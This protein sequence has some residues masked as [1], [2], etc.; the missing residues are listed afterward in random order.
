MPRFYSIIENEHIRIGCTGETVWVLD[1]NDTVLA[2]FKDLSY[3]YRAAISPRGDLLAVKGG[4]GRLAIYS[5]KEL[6][7]IKKFRFSKVNYGQDDGFC[8]S[9][10][11]KYLLNIERHEDDLHSAISVYDTAD[12]SLVSRALQGENMM[13]EHVQEVDGNYY[14][15]GFLRGDDL[16]IRSYCV[17][18]YEN[19]CICDIFKIT[20][21]EHSLYRKDLDRSVFG[22]SYDGAKEPQ[23]IHTLGEL[24]AHYRGAKS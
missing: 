23:P 21:T 15:L 19:G 5:L 24:W 12:F 6:S 4:Q 3:A 10:D 20:E 7:L 13:I 14:V 9:S 17:A 22:E 2:K 16:V 8:F 18:K 11:G 1:K